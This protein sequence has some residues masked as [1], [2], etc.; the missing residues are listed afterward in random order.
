[1]DFLWFKKKPY[2][3]RMEKDYEKRYLIRV[4]I[5]ACKEIIKL[6]RAGEQEVSV[7]YYLHTISSPILNM[8]I[9]FKSNEVMY[10][11]DIEKLI[12]PYIRE[13]KLKKLI[14]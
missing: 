7:F 9:I 14:K 1:M 11:E 4:V 12:L 3:C 13:Y 10:Q 5:E 2:I 8:N 6:E